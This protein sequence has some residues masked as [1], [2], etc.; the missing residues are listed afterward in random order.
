M[1]RSSALPSFPVGPGLLIRST[2]LAFMLCIL[3]EICHLVFASHFAQSPF[4]D[5]KVVTDKSPD[6]N[7]TLLTG[8]RA[9]KG[10]LVQVRYVTISEN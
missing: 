4:Q 10:P 2:L 1:N 9:S 7:G 3:P 6:P 5:G 8:L